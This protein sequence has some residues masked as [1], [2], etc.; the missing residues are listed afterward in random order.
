VVNKQRAIFMQGSDRTSKPTASGLMG[1]R[2]LGTLLGVALWMLFCF[3]QYSEHQ[4]QSDLIQMT[5]SSQ[6]EVLSNAVA[7]NLQSHRWF[8]PFVQQQLP[9]TLESLAKADNVLAIVVVVNDD[10]DNTYSAGDATLADTSM[11]DGEHFTAG[12]L[13][14]VRS[15]EVQNN[16]PAHGL[17]SES[18][19]RGPVD[20]FRSIIVLDRSDTLLQLK[21]EVRTRLLIVTLGSLVLLAAAIGWR[22]TV[23]LTQA[24]GQARLLAVEARHLSELGQAAAGLA[25]ETRNPLGLIRGWTQRLVDSGLPN[26]DQQSQ[27][28]AVLEE[29]D[30]VTARINQFLA[31]ARPEEV[32]LEAVSMNRLID[33]LVTLLQSDLDDRGVTLS[34]AGLDETRNVRADHNQLRQLL[35]NLLQN[36]ISFA[37][38][39]TTISISATTSTSGK[40]RLEIADEG[41][42]VPDELADSIFDPYVTRRAGGTGLGLS[43]VRRIAVAHQWDVGY[44]RRSGG[45]SIFWIDG[46]TPA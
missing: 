14:F 40:L 26:S 22:F 44:K 30:R 37:P 38:A 25:H 15:F 21:R 1:R 16:P 6:A 7:G 19:S 33:D 12:T 17:F 39:E 11:L 13:Q 9:N 29:C 34:S 10:R 41:P 45:G 24:E 46:I 36:A 8:G 42:G 27:A 2:I 43:I 20:S 35:F 5:L 31:F 32:T 28:E 23:R 3:W 4:R 18:E